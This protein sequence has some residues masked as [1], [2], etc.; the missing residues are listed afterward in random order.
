MEDDVL[1]PLEPAGLDRGA[2]VAD[3]E[4]HAVL[5]GQ[6]LRADADDG[7][8]VPQPGAKQRPLDAFRQPGPAAVGQADDL[9][10]YR[11]GEL[12]AEVVKPSTAV[13]LQTAEQL[14]GGP[15]HH[16][17]VAGADGL[18]REEAR[19]RRPLAPMDV[20]VEKED[21]EVPRAGRLHLLGTRARLNH[22]PAAQDLAAPLEATD[23]PRPGIGMHPLRGQ[24]RRLT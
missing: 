5:S 10:R 18:G 22:L 11:D 14:I 7:V 3:E 4:P 15:L 12:V 20:T 17:A 9:G 16:Q 13:R 6:Q 24:G 1:L 23:D 2:D 21:R 8:R 19:D